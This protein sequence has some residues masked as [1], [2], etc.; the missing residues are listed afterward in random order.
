[1]EAVIA[2]SQEVYTEA[3][4]DLRIGG[5]GAAN[6]RVLAALTN[7]DHKWLREVM[8]PDIYTQF[9]ALNLR[10]AGGD[11]RLEIFRPF[12]A[13]LELRKR[14]L[15]QL[16]L[17]SDGQV[18]ATIG[19]LARKHYVKVVPMNALLKPRPSELISKLQR[20]PAQADMECAHWQLLQLERE[21]RD[22]MLRANAWTAGDMA[23]LRQDWEGSRRQRQ[24]ASC[25]QLFQAIAPAERAIRDTRRSSVTALQKALKK[26]RTTLALMTLEDV[27]DPDGVL[28]GLRAAGY[29]VEEPRPEAVSAPR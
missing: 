16:Q 21:L 22:T 7:P 6:E 1:V 18:H 5:N 8:P 14:A 12:Y 11:A 9:D 26:N 20:M 13:A 17:N 3:L 24:Q 28:A 23:A 15:T 29:L 10:Y 19:Y 27:L 2:Q 25:M 4:V